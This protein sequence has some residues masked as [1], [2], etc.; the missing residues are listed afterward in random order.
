MRLK[1]DC[2]IWPGAK[3][4]KGYGVKWDPNKKRLDRL[5]RLAGESHNGP[6]P[7]GLVIRHRCDNPSCFNIDHLEIGCLLY[8]SDAADEP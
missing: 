2:V 7:A 8:T 4:S 1:G 3:D 5:H 6:I